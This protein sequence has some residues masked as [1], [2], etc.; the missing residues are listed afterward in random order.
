MILDCDIDRPAFRP[1]VVNMRFT[2]TM[3]TTLILMA[4]N[5]CA[6][7]GA[8]TITNK[9]SSE[10]KINIKGLCVSQAQTKEI[11][12]LPSD[13]S[14]TEDWGLCTIKSLDIQNLANG[15]KCY[16]D[17]KVGA[18][19]HESIDITNYVLHKGGLC[20]AS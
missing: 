6:Y 14:V 7:C 4:M 8:I 12:K 10:L 15:K 5:Q 18:F 2:T 11:S 20:A 17:K 3:L 19:E 1:G 13:S 16:M 9:T